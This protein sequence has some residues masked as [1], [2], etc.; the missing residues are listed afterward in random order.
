MRVD[1]HNVD[2]DEHREPSGERR[3]SSGW[4]ARAAPCRSVLAVGAFAVGAVPT[5][6]AEVLPAV[7]GDLR[8]G[9]GVAGQLVT[10]FAVA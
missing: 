1:D 6:I 10:A 2:F 7:A 3:L 8:V 4:N 9:V 5:V